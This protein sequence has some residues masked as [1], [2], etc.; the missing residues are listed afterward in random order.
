[1][2]NDDDDRRPP[3]FSYHAHQVFGFLDRHGGSV[4]IGPLLRWSRLSSDDLAAAVNELAQRHW[5]KITWRNRPRAHLPDGLPERFRAVDRVTT[6]G[7]GRWRYPVTW[8]R[9]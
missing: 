5:V 1:M 4:R 3:P 8:Q 7:F 9:Y 2:H 6:T